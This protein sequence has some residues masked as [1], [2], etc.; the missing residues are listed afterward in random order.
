MG[1]VVRLVETGVDGQ[2]RSF[3]VTEIGRPGGLGEIAN[4]G[5]TLAEG[6]QLL[7]GVQQV[8]VAAQAEDQATLRPDC[9]SCGRRCHV[10]DWKPRL[11]ATL[12][13][14]V[15][16]PLPRF[17]C[18]GCGRTETG[19]SWPSHCRST[20]ELDQ[21]QARLSALMA[22]RVAADLLVHVLPIDAGKSAEMLRGHTLRVGAQLGSAAADQPVAAA[23]AI[24]MSLDSTFI[25]GC[26]AGERHLEIRL[27]NVET[28]GGGRQV[29]GAVAQAD[30]DITALIRRNLPIVG[31]TDDTEVTAFTDGC[32]G[33]RS[34][35]AD[36]GVT[37]PPILDWFHIAMQLQHTT[38]AASGLATNNPDR[39]Q[40]KALIVA[41]V[42]RLRWRI[43]NGK[44][45]NAQRS[46]KRIRKVI[47]VF[48]DERGHR[49]R[50]VSSGK[51][52]G[53]LHKVDSYLRGQ[54]AWLVNYAKR[55]RAGLRVGTSITEGTANFLVNR[56]MKKSQQMRWS[57]R[58]ADLLLQVR[59]AVYN[60]ALGSGFGHRFE[61]FVVN[62]LAKGTPYRRPKGTPA[63]RLVPVVHRGDPRDAECPFKG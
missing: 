35:L 60:G 5:L 11:I 34:T 22:Y 16:V 53:A 12:F 55:Y 33:L 2:S 1:W 18:A 25:R 9:R 30:T 44:A 61:V 58:G 54:G 38:Q 21:L 28:A 15:R 23:S 42:E 63:Q 8:V 41:E 3:D 48:Q 52:W 29:F 20:P 46:I 24:T 56:R 49:T 51:L 17:L 32:S 37:K 26:E 47:H 59:C 57:R 31:R 13:G 7:A 6:K 45:K 43:W 36:A 4:P 62:R 40:A 27:G 50:G 14:E 19:V 10:K 39:M